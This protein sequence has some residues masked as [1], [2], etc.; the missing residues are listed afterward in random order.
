ME[1]YEEMRNRHQKEFNAFPCFFAFDNKQFDEGMKKLGVESK[2]EIYSGGNGMYYRKADSPKLM[3]MMDRFDREQTE[4]YKD[5]NFL[6]NAMVY[7]LGNHE[8][9]ITLDPEPTMEALGMKLKDLKDER[10]NRIFQQ[11]KKEYFHPQKKSAP[12]R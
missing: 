7:E 1:T 6:K 3:E 2:Q 5:D 10:V 12:V 9:C 8:F 11:A 4:A